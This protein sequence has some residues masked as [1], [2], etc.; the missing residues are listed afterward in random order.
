MKNLTDFEVYKLLDSMNL[1]ES[2]C[3][4][5]GASPNEIRDAADSTNDFDVHDRFYINNGTNTA[6]HFP[7]VLNSLLRSIELDKIETSRISY[8]SNV[9]SYGNNSEIKIINP[10]MTYIEKPILVEWLKQRGVYPEALFPLE[11][12]NEILNE[13]HPFYSNKLAM[14]VDAWQQLKYAELDNQTVKN[15]LESWIKEHS[16]KYGFENM[17]ET[18]I[19]NL[20]EIVNFEK[21]G[22][23]IKGSLVDAF[24]NL[25]KQHMRLIKKQSNKQENKDDSNGQIIEGDLPF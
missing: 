8:Y 23:R 10:V 12:D 19:S 7:L 16:P 2:A 18:A 21:G 4:I 15:Y 6:R 3:L 22:R 1:L 20:A 11:P 9:G 14:I 5:V 13:E 24:D 17:G 25:E